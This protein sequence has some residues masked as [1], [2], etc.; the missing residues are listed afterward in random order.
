MGQRP[1][2]PCYFLIGLCRGERSALSRS[3]MKE[4]GVGHGGLEPYSWGTVIIIESN[5]IEAWA[6]HARVTV[7]PWIQFSDPHVPD[8]LSPWLFLAGVRLRSPTS[9]RDTLNA[10]KPDLLGK[11]TRQSTSGSD[12][13]GSETDPGSKKERIYALFQ[14]TVRA[15]CLICLS[16]HSL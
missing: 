4:G 15:A 6:A 16:L 10:D 13:C 9:K 12:V 1:K 5:C 3:R 8:P 14:H 7:S 11:R 2:T